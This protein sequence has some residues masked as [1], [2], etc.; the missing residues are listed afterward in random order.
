[1]EWV[2]AV[3]VDVDARASSNRFA[4][5][6]VVRKCAVLVQEVASGRREADCNAGGRV[7]GVEGVGDSDPP[8]F[9]LTLSDILRKK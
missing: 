7:R 5:V 3:D 4:E 6:W 1:M 9:R 8:S 2:V